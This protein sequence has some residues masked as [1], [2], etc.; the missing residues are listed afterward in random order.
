VAIASDIL[1]EET[2]RLAKVKTNEK[3]TDAEIDDRLRADGL[4]K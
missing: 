1:A 2:A 3:L 4:I